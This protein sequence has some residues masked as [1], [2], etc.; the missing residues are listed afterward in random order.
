MILNPGVCY[1]FANGVIFHPRAHAL[2]RVGFDGIAHTQTLQEFLDFW[3]ADKQITLS[4]DFDVFQ[5]PDLVQWETY[6]QE[7]HLENDLQVCKC[8]QKIRRDYERI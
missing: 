7:K 4:D 8:L 3:P 1:Y 5:N 2:R 6:V